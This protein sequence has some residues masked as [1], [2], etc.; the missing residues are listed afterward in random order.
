V[1]EKETA[2]PAVTLCLSA[3][4]IETEGP[5]G[6]P[7]PNELVFKRL[8]SGGGGGDSCNGGGGGDGGGEVLAIIAAAIK[9]C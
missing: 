7:G 5:V 8:L 9:C 6:Q 1:L 2:D 3:V 4:R